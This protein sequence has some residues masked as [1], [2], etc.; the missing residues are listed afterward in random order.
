MPVIYIIFNVL[1]ILCLIHY[2]IDLTNIE[3]Y[4][5]KWDDLEL[6]EATDVLTT[7]YTFLYIFI[8]IFFQSGPIALIGFIIISTIL[9]KNATVKRYILSII[10]TLTLVIANNMIFRYQLWELIINLLDI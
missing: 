6:L 3:L 8:N 1:A 7:I 9:K 2:I 5:I 4:I 10:T